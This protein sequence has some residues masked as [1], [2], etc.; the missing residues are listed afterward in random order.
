MGFFAFRSGY[1]SNLECPDFFQFILYKFKFFAI[2]IA[3]EFRS[4]N[5]SYKICTKF[6]CQKNI[7]KLRKSTDFYKWTRNRM[8]I[9][10]LRFACLHRFCRKNLRRIYLPGKFKHFCSIKIFIMF[11]KSFY[12]S[13]GFFRIFCSKFAQKNSC[14]AH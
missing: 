10:T 2:N 8:R 13:S 1:N 12:K 14:K 4:K 3:S 6:I 5:K 11:L 7:A 9:S